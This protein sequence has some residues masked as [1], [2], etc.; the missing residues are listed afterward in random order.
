[1]AK[2][3]GMGDVAFGSNV[4]AFFA[5]DGLNE[6]GPIV[7]EVPCT[8]AGDTEDSFEV[9]DV[10]N[11]GE[12]SGTV[13]ADD[14]VD[15]EELVRSTETTVI[16]YPLGSNTTAKTKTGSAFL[17]SAARTGVKNGLNTYAVVFQWKTKPTTVDAT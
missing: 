1:M 7:P 15:T 16:T 4:M 11:W 17:K 10:R 14:T 9:G 13:I 3:I 5:D 8:A 2:T 6:T 12:F